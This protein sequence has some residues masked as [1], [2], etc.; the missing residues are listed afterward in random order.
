MCS[1]CASGNVFRR[2]FHFSHKFNQLC[3]VHDHSSLAKQTFDRLSKW[4]FQPNA[5]LAFILFWYH[6]IFIDR[7]QQK[8]W[9]NYSYCLPLSVIQLMRRTV[10]YAQH[11]RIHRI[12][13]VAMWRK[14]KKKQRKKRIENMTRYHFGF[15]F[16]PTMRKNNAIIDYA[17]HCARVRLFIYHSSL[18]RSWLHE[19]FS[20]LLESA[21]QFLW[22]NQK[23]W[24]LKFIQY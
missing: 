9:Q 10:R 20:F 11:T 4:L 21:V 23:R 16:V 5:L 18:F 17:G 8:Q 3:V 13:A 14:T 19:C 12:R 15:D 24:P 7:K 2:N 1:V 22:A 6:S